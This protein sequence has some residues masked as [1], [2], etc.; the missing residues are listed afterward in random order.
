M[1]KLVKSIA[2][3]LAFGFATAVGATSF[4][5]DNSDLWWI[6]TESGWGLQLVQQGSFIFA[7]VFIYGTNGQPTWITAQMQTIGTYLWSGPLYVTSGSFFGGAFTSSI[8][9]VRQAG[10]MTWQLTSV[11]AG[12]LT[13]SVDGVPVTKN[14]VRQFLATDSYSGV[15]RTMFNLVATSCVNPANN[16]SVSDSILLTISQTNTTASMYWIYSDGSSCSLP[17]GSYQQAGRMGQMFGSY[18]C[19]SGDAGTMQF[20]EMTNRINMVSGRILGKSNVNGCSYSGHFTGLVP[21]NG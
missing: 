19:T 1:K 17:A 4:S 20:V 16:G 10:T 5:T 12:T 18:S 7:T 9:T 8:V 15:Y 6:P 11:R 3:V 14:V 2:I 21:L 13:Y